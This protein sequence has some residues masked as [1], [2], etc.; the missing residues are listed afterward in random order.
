MIDAHADL[1][2]TVCVPNPNKSFVSPAN[3]SMIH[4]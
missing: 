3:L 1:W 4:I 2:K